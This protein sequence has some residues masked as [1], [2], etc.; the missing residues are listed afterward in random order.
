MIMEKKKTRETV[1][2]SL[3]V[4]IYNKLKD[5]AKKDSRSISSMIRVIIQK[6]FK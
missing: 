5:E 6:Y 1:R 3:P 4:P 2:A